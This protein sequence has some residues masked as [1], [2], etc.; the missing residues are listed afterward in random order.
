[1]TVWRHL[2]KSVLLLTVL[3]SWVVIRPAQAITLP[4]G[5]DLPPNATQPTVV[6]VSLYVDEVSHIDVTHQ[7]FVITG[8]L[9]R[10]WQD[11]RLP[12]LFAA[13]PE[14]S[15]MEFEGAEAKEKLQRLW[16]PVLQ[17]VNEKGQR[18]TGVQSLQIN[19]D[20]WVVLYEKFESEPHLSGDMQMFPF[21]I[22]NLRVTLAGISQPMSELVLRVRDFGFQNGS[23]ADSAIIGKW[24]FVG[25]E[26]S[27]GDI[28]RSDELDRRYPRLDFVL[29]VRQDPVEGFVTYILPILLIGLVSVAL[30][31]LDAA[32]N[33]SYSGPRVGGTLTLILTTVA[34]ELTLQ[35]SL[36]A[37]HYSILPKLLL[38][39][40]VIMLTL[41]VMQS[42]AQIWL[43]HN[44]H[45]A[46]SIWVDQFWRIVYP[47]AFALLAMLLL[48]IC[49]YG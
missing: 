1:M 10:K 34:L 42:C 23:D 22:E 47:L 49:L 31:F 7:T 3:A 28:R 25:S 12:K 35:K 24:N 19:R 39:L 30:L 8:Q 32:Q 44:G 16:H 2:I 26:F 9:V 17:I 45:Q 37:V 43:Y 40:T 4:D 6:D 29:N 20:G 41:S 48:G 27:E 21:A 14:A 13:Y 18:K 15:I 38:N 46:R 36:P 5:Y 33:P 11:P